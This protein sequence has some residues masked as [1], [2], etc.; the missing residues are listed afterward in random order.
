MRHFKVTRG[1]PAGGKTFRRGQIITEG[2]MVTR[3]GEKAVPWPNLPALLRSGH[4]E[5][6]LNH[7]EEVA[8]DGNS[9][10]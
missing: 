4:I 2:E 7:Q 5:E 10:T 3:Q 9:S 1:F 8:K 6:I